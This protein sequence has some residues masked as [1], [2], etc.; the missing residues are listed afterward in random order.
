MAEDRSTPQSNKK[1]AGKPDR[2]FMEHTYRYHYYFKRTGRYRF[3]GKNLLRVFGVIAAFAAG[4]WFVTTYL[5]DLDTV[6]NFIFNRFPKWVV[7]GTLLLSES[8]I[9][10]LPPDLYIFW[11]KTL[12]NPYAMVLVLSLVSYAGGVISYFVGTQLY[13]I[14]RVKQWVHVRFAEQF[15]A[16]RKYGGL[17]IFISAMAPLPFSWVSVVSGVVKYPLLKFLLIALSRLLRFF[18]Y[19]FV[20]YQ[21]LA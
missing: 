6:M 15:L 10:L 16:F 18:L 20:F 14:P 17:L 3:V 1:K 21:V 19:A 4:A 8:V 9:G 5:I 7:V 11:A 2:S 13:K 12:P